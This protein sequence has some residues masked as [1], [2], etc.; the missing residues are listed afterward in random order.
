M[1][2]EETKAVTEVAKAAGEFAK[3]GGK[4]VDASA[5]FGNWLSETI[6]TIP[7]DL[8]GIAGGDWLHEQRKRN[9][10]S[11]QAKTA[12]IRKRINA[13]P[14][15]EPSVSVVLPLL[16][17][18]SDEA[19]PELQELWAGLLASS[20]QSDGGQ[21]VR[22]AFFETLSKMEPPDARLFDAITQKKLASRGLWSDPI[23]VGEQV[24]ITGEDLIVSGD[25]LKVLG[26]LE[27]GPSGTRSTQYGVAFWKAC[28]P[29]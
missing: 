9:L 18:A 3:A 24:G 8:L 15:Q 21:K 23:S 1:S 25:A 7:E 20:F 19:R 17:A 22:R 28:N 6:G 14:P 16:K 2:G 10:L 27:S 13:G 5:G 26:L 29:R 4:V 12:E 11:L